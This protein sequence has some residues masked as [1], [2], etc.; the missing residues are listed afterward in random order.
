M[1]NVLQGA[2]KRSSSSDLPL[3]AEISPTYLMDESRLKGNANKLFF[4]ISEEHIAGIIQSAIINKEK[5][6]LSGARTGITGGAVP[7]GGWLISF[8]KMNKILGMRWDA[9]KNAFF[10]RVEPG[11]TLD[12]I[13]NALLRK[14]FEDAYNWDTSSQNA[15]K[16]FQETPEKWIFPP[17]PT[18]RSASIGGMVACNASGARTFHYGAT[19]N[20][21]NRIKMLTGECISLDIIRGKIFADQNNT[22]IYRKPDGSPCEV[23]LPCYQMPELKNASGYYYKPEMDI[24][25]LFIGSEGTLAVFTEFELELIKAPELII[26]IIGFFKSEQEALN[27]VIDARNE[28]K[29]KATKDKPC[30]LAIEYFDY[31][32]LNLLRD[33]KAKKAESSAIPA[34]PQNAHTAVYIEVA[35]SENGIEED[36]MFVME[37][38]EKNGSS[39]DT[40][41]SATT[42]EEEERLKAFRHAL[43]ETVNQ[44]IAERA[45]LHKGL[46]KL[47]TDFAVPDDYL[48]DIIKTYRHILDDSKLEY[49]M[50]GH[51]GNNHLHLNILPRDMNEYNFGKELYKQI[52]Q[53]VV[54]IKGTVSAEH[55]IGKLKKSFLEMMYGKD[56]IAQFVKIK[57]AFDPNWMLNPGNLFEHAT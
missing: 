38:L 2:L 6:T 53:E 10:L 13:N 36:V 54:K 39:S 7:N 35:S 17:D 14:H 55:G 11:V 27:F 37:L 15:L 8:E 3:A 47:G 32:A 1:N 26:G 34:L 20:Y 49:V 52:A 57:K 40:A 45:L 42:K 46:T 16:K 51:I 48:K 50:F 21:I 30:V 44:R 28:N 12:N 18:E 23:A 31:K 19:R 22:F 9:G 4:P 41:W 5:I 29:K 24:I 33:E 43:P 56:V 25:D